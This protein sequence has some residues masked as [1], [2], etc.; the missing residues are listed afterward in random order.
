ME[1]HAIL[2]TYMD[3]EADQLSQFIPKAEQKYKSF[4]Q[5]YFDNPGTLKDELHAAVLNVL[6]A[7]KLKIY[8]CGHGGT[9]IDYIMNNALNRKQTLE[10]LENLLC[11][12]LKERATS[13]D[14]SALT[15]VNMI[16]CLFG[17]TAD[18]RSD[19][20]PAVKLHLKLASRGVYIQLVARTECASFTNKGVQTIS[21]IQYHVYEPYFG[22]DL[23][24]KFYSRKVPYSKILCQ[25]EG[26]SPIV[27]LRG[28]DATPDKYIKADTVTA[29][30]TLWADYVINEFVKIIRL[31]AGKIT[32]AREQK[33]AM[34]VG[35]YDVNHNPQ[36]L[37]QKMEA[38]VDGTG[39]DEESNFTKHRNAFSKVIA[40]TGN[41]QLPKKAQL[42][43]DL[44]AK[45]P[46]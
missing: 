12:A 5:L 34:L 27:S 32:D 17:R 35:V 7:D 1:K 29:K 22:K 21:A 15:E 39:D 38:L 40:L 44:L 18:G 42:I 6:D 2:L 33:L 14:T 9:G 16:S 28:F 30:R 41:S 3:L 24:P 36:L 4:K 19:S 10:D 8:I 31:S 43:K 20:S 37:K 23:R 11:F 13:P 25:F 46:G 26:K 45:Y